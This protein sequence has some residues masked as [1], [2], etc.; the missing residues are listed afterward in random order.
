MRKIS[1]G[2]K[3]LIGLG[4]AIVILMIS[5]PSLKEFKEYSPLQ[6][7]NAKRTRNWIIFSIYEN[8]NGK[9]YFGI[10]KNFF[11]LEDPYG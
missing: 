11:E 4:I 1:I 6:S 3:I 7:Y 10:F 8:N 2:K 5:N 9:R